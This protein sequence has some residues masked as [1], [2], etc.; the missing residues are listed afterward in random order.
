MVAVFFFIQRTRQ[1]S[2]YKCYY[3]G[4]SFHTSGLPRS[5]FIG[6]GEGGFSFFISSFSSVTSLFISA[7]AAISP[8]S[9]PADSTLFSFSPLFFP[10]TSGVERDKEKSSPDL[11]EKLF[12]QTP[13]SPV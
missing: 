13:G 12:A 2:G 5:F 1:K 7:R 8:L 4:N 6:R 10:P 11:T 9:V 3:L